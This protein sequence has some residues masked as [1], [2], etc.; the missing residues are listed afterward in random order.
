MKAL[1]VTPKTKAE[2]RFLEELLHKLGFIATVMDREQLE[3]AGLSLLMKEAD[4]KKKVSRET[5]MKKLKS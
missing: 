3:D 2:I 5:V 4:R 1:V